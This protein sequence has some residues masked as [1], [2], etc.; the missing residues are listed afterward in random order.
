VLLALA[1]GY[2][3]WYG[4]WELS[5][6]GGDFGIDPVVDVVETV[7]LRIVQAI[8]SIGGGLLSAVVA[9]VVVA[10]IVLTRRPST[11]TADAAEEAPRRSANE[12]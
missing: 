5:V 4:R 6:Y 9:V 7:R 10:A 2:A 3:I 12:R 8:E 1:G 11:D